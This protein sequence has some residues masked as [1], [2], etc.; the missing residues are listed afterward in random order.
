M[1]AAFCTGLLFDKYRGGSTTAA[2]SY[3]ELFVI[4]VNDQKPLPIITRSS[5]QDFAAVLDRPLKQIF[6]Y[7][8]FFFI[9]LQNIVKEQQFKNLFFLFMLHL[10]S[11]T[12]GAIKIPVGTERLKLGLLV[13]TENVFVPTPA[14][15]TRCHS[16]G[17]NCI[18]KKYFDI[19][20][21]TSSS[22]D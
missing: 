16:H 22:L 15:F 18:I 20:S 14:Y 13:L 9:N 4:I 5:T 11:V 21:S 8:M 7:W 1:N 6:I 12:V 17:C 2:T 19:L 10:F 3:V